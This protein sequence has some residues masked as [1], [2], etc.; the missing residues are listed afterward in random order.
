MYFWLHHKSRIHEYWKC[1]LGY[2][3]IGITTP[4]S[5]NLK[6]ATQNVHILL[7]RHFV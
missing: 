3:H 5:N 2:I 1:E 7:N 6:K 4:L